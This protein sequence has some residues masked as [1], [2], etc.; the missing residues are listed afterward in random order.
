VSDWDGR[1]LPPIAMQRIERARASG[2]RTSLLSVS[3]QAGLDASGFYAVGEVMGCAVVHLGFQGYGGCG[4]N[5]MT[6]YGY[7][8]YTVTARSG[9][10]FGFGPYL[11]ALESSW[12]LALTRLLSEAAGL[13]ADGVVGI[14]LTEEHLGEGNREFVALGTA[15]RSIGR[16]HLQR[17]F[18]TTLGG[19]DVTKLL[20]SGFS[21]AGAIVAISLGI[22]HDDYATRQATMMFAG[23]VEVPG[24]SEL[25]HVVRSDVRDELH[26]RT[27]ALGANGAILT[28]P[29]SLQIHELEVAEGHRD[30]IALATLV[31]SA[32]V[33]TGTPVAAAAHPIPVVFLD[34][35][36]KAG[37]R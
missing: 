26:R 3:S 7:P 36:P 31:A 37:T 8:Q 11:Q 10:Y 9:G 6:G 30:H 35:K 28:Y 22:R 21:P 34:D 29:M 20:A 4:W 17:P 16:T 1:G 24:Y 12:D 13:G 2:V 15:V 23:N 32:I 14:K 25:V 27:A 33:A 19:D 5:P 18:T